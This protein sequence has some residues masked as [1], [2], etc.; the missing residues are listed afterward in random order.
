MLNG[1]K[2]SSPEPGYGQ[3]PK[4]LGILAGV[5]ATKKRTGG[6]ILTL[7]GDIIRA[8]ARMSLPF[9]IQT[10]RFGTLLCLCLQQPLHSVNQ[11]AIID[12]R[13]DSN[14]FQCQ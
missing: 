9:K 10:I 5:L 1:L 7:S 13:G 14:E 12:A 2:L 4:V 11:K 6:G 8:A 3:N